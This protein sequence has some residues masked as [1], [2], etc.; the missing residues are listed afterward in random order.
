MTNQR[1]AK[2]ITRYPLSGGRSS[3][4]S[5]VTIRWR[6]PLFTGYLVVSGAIWLARRACI[7]WLVP[8]PI[9]RGPPDAPDRHRADAREEQKKVRSK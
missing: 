6:S 3:P 7:R 8:P 1:V 4:D 2:I 5:P 9:G